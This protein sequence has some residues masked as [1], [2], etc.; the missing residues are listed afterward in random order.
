MKPTITAKIN[1]YNQTIVKLKYTE[2]ETARKEYGH[3]KTVSCRHRI[4]RKRK[5]DK[6]T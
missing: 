4:E 6:E 2:S 3:S 5:I 1:Y